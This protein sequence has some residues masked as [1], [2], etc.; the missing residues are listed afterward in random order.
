M[1]V[2][3]LNHT[4]VRINSVHSQYI[5]WISQVF[6]GPGRAWAVNREIYAGAQ[7]LRSSM[8]RLLN[9]L[10][11]ALKVRFLLYLTLCHVVFHVYRFGL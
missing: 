10:E 6:S 5:S 9:S 4:G 11:D 8:I 2:Y 3:Q 7:S 1:T